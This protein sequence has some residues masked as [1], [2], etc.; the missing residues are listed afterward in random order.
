MPM[1]ADAH[2]GAQNAVLCCRSF[3]HT[4]LI[5]ATYHTQ[6]KYLRTRLIYTAYCVHR[7]ARFSKYDIQA[8]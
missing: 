5:C 6:T 7:L 1:L 8:K 4:I 2:C 3:I